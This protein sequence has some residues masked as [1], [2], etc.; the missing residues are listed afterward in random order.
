MDSI[1]S[2][3][4]LHVVVKLSLYSTLTD[5]FSLY[6]LAFEELVGLAANEVMIGSRRKDISDTSNEIKEFKNLLTKDNAS[7]FSTSRR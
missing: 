7:G 2:D 1:I 4:N 3:P 5:G 6:I